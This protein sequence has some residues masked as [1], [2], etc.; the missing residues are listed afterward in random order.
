MVKAPAALLLAPEVSVS[1]KVLWL[2]MQTLDPAAGTPSVPY[3]R[4]QTGLAANTIRQGLTQ[5]SNMPTLPNAPAATMPEDLL[6]SQEIRP[7]ARLL[8]GV[9]QLTPGYRHP[10][11]QTTYAELSDMTGL[12]PRPT[13]EAFA[14]LV[15]T[16]WLQ[17]TQAGR[18]APLKFKL[19]RPAVTLGNALYENA[20]HR[21][22]RRRYGGEAI[23]REF[24]TLLIDSAQF[25]DDAA[26]GFLVNPVTRE[27]LQL[28]RF[29]P[30]LKVAFE[31]QGA[32]HFGETEQVS[33][34]ESRQQQARDLM[35]I[36]MCVRQGIT[37]VEVL[38]KELTFKGLQKKVGALQVPLRDLKGQ[39]R[40]IRFLSERASRYR[41][42]IPD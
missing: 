16:G 29:Y 20:L 28:D 26:P 25:Q 38:P 9:L 21:L 11:G 37:L 41:S 3:L 24:L 19:L 22:T 2:L 33:E 36:G 31:Y 40:L 34:E 4:N 32:Q 15:Q 17:F 30:E 1:T 10:E 8:Y 12:S 7:Q 23:M 18:K 39:D 14:A 5:L 42:K 13:R 27:R 6:T 35:K